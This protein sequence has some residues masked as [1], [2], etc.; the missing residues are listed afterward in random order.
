MFEPCLFVGQKD[1]S[2]LETSPIKS[3][4]SGNFLTDA[5]NGNALQ[6]QT[7]S[8][9]LCTLEEEEEEKILNNDA[10]EAYTFSS[11]LSKTLREILTD[12]SALGYFIQFMDTRKSIA[13]IKFWLEVEC[14]CSAS[15]ITHKDSEKSECKSNQKKLLDAMP[16]SLEDNENFSCKANNVNIQ[17]SRKISFNENVDSNDTASVLNDMPKT[18]KEINKTRQ[19]NHDCGNKRH[20]MTTARQDA[21]RIYKKYI[22]KGI[23]GT[24]QISEK[25]R[26]EMEEVMVQ[27]NIEPILQCLS[28]VQS[29]VYDI[30]ENE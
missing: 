19:S 28:T 8:G 25:L 29:L 1:K 2:G 17:V 11:Q 24:N 3:T 12:K 22:L 6:F 26:L 21:L 5:F 15:G 20:D 7:P 9:V 13:L 23:L 10:E 18:S 4:N 16:T 30:L 14:L 27:E